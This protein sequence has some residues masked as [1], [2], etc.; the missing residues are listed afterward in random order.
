[1]TK[2]WMMG[3]AAAAL[4][5]ATAVAAQAADLPTRKAPPAPVY[6]PPPFSWTGFYVGVNA[7]GIWGTGNTTT[8]F[9]NAGFPVL[10]NVN[11]GALGTGASGFIGGG[12][13]G[14]NFQSGAAVFG[15]ETDFDGTSMSKSKS[16]IGN[17]FAYNS[18][19]DYFTTNASTRL[20][21]LGTTRARVGFVATPDNRL[22]LYG[23][24]GLAYGGGNG[25]ASVYDAGNGWGWA[26]SKSNTRIGWTIGA[27]AEY[28]ITNNVTVKGEY[29]YYNL[30]TTNQVGVATGAALAAFPTSYLASKVTY[31]G[32]IFRA[33]LNYKF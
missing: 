6:V 12:Q 4:T 1:M 23:T 11:Y 21:W 14:Y 28:A 25:N 15:L 3:A 8:T 9:Y 31:E 29:L 2:R 13:A 33:G 17:T 22:M 10:S 32:S 24:G 30:G 18:A 7:G 20:N 19:N 16:R 5:I 26:G 27:G